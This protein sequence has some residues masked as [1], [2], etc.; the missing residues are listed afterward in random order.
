MLARGPRAVPARPLCAEADEVV[1]FDQSAP[2]EASCVNDACEVAASIAL[3]HSPLVGPTC[4]RWVADELIELGHRVIVPSL[5]AG[6]LSGRWQECVQLAAART[7]PIEDEVILVGHSGAGPLLPL[8]ADAMERPPARLVFVDA[9]LP[10]R[11]G[12]IALVP[13]EF[14]EHLRRLARDGVLPPWSDWFGPDTMTALIPDDQRRLEVLAD[15]P[16]I[17]LSYFTARIA[18]PDRWSEVANGA[19]ILLSEIYQPDALEARSRGWPTVERIGGHLDLVTRPAEVAD[20]I[21][22]LAVR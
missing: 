7:T 15:M 20:S 16:A 5:R 8:I 10:P 12:D 3:I 19:Y 4:W 11:Y 14:A 1:A 22:S 13:D 18:L 6:A 2:L 17:P 9:S 21:R